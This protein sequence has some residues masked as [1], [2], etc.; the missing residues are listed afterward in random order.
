MSTAKA[1]RTWQI[2]FRGKHI[3]TFP[4]LSEFCYRNHPAI[5]REN[6]KFKPPYRQIFVSKIPAVLPRRSI[7]SQNRN[8]K[9]GIQNIQCRINRKR[10]STSYN[11][12]ARASLAFSRI[13]PYL[14]KRMM[15]VL[16]PINCFQHEMVL[17]I[18]Q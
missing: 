15:I 7:A 9:R 17:N 1:L 14:R 3:R 13:R 4:T 5:S 18:M 11:S 6:G 8:I 12:Y 2:R 16:H 10:I